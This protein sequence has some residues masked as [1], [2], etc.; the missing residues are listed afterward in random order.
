MSLVVYQQ[1]EDGLSV[2]HPSSRPGMARAG[3]SSIKLAR[4]APEVVDMNTPTDQLVKMA[5]VNVLSKASFKKKARGTGLP[6]IRKLSGAAAEVAAGHEV[7]R[8]P[9]DTRCGA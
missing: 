7:T 4:L 1:E 5:L 6:L 9:W 8:S 2:H 3:S